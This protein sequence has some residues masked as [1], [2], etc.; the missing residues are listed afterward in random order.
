MGGDEE[1]VGRKQKAVG[2]KQ[3]ADSRKHIAENR[4]IH[5]LAARGEGAEN[6]R[7]DELEANA[8]IQS[9]SIPF[10]LVIRVLTFGLWKAKWKIRSK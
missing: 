8:L 2:R 7:G 10:F 9:A 4:E 3:K 1:E 6:G 5:G